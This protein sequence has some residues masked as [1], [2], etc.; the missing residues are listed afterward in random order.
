VGAPRLPRAVIPLYGI[1]FLDVLGFTILIPLLPYI[2]AKYGT[3]DVVTG[4]LLTTTAACATLSSPLWGA[5][6]DRFG[7]RTALLGSQ[8]FSF[9]GYLMLA[10]AG[11]LGT[12]FASRVIEGLGGGSAGIANSYLAD[13]TPEADRPHAFALGTAAFGA[14]F[15]VGPILG[16]LLAHFGFVVP[17]LVAAAL[18]LACSVLTATLLVE[19]P[20]DPRARFRWAEVRAALASRPVA[21]ILARRFLYIFA[22][23]Y[24]FT[25]FSLYASH[26]FGAGPATSSFLLAVAG[27]VGAF[28]QVAVVGRLAKRYGLHR[29]ALG[30][31]ALGTI[32]YLLLDLVDG[33]PFF[34]VVVVAWAFSGSLLRP[35]LD[36][37]I[38]EVATANDRGTLLSLGDALDNL[39]LIFAPTAGAAILGSAP[40]YAGLV[41]A[42]CLAA[43]FTLTA[44]ERAPLPPRA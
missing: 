44:R 16:G 35:V 37:R 15:V 23:T 5:L 10:F 3:A 29:V 7:R 9:V 28:T 20:R 8:A 17:L 13:L 41:P 2:A 39:S 18:Q 11:G 14:G 22:F 36:A 19:A 32:A 43:A 25:M 34:V 21:S 26:R 27:A 40:S 30:A 4:T 6:S 31:F 42:L 1:T 12:V 24:F 38:A 33:L